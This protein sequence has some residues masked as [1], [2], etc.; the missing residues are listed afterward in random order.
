LGIT[1]AKVSAV[2]DGTN[3]GQVQPTDWNADHVGGL[4]QSYVGY[5]TIGGAWTATVGGRMYA[6][7][8]TLASAAILLA[9]EIHVRP[10]ADNFSDIEGLVAEDS[11]STVG[12]IIGGASVGAVLMS[13]ATSGFPGT[14]RWFSIPIGKYLTAASY[15]IGFRTGAAILDIA[16]DASGS[17]RYW[18]NTGGN[19]ISGNHAS[20]TQTDSTLKYSIRASILS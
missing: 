13:A 17:D 19:Y 14:G 18:T 2:P 7:K 8:V 3:A 16:N 5:N 9:I 10:N 4:S 6:K 1:H 11:A 12:L 20:L 15:W